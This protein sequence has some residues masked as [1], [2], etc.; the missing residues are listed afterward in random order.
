MYRDHGAR[1]PALRT[2]GAR[3]LLRSLTDAAGIELDDKHGYLAPHGARRGVGEALVK[4]RGFDEAA[5]QL[6]NEAST[7]Q[8]YYAELTAR[9][10]SEDRG[11]AFEAHDTGD[12]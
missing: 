8:R 7:T 4:E 11:Q 12:E 2:D 6:D 3:D 10:R 5:D 1:P 9:E